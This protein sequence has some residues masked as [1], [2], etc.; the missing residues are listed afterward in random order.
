[1]T[2]W[3]LKRFRWE[4]N[5][6]PLHALACI[7]SEGRVPRTVSHCLPGRMG[8]PGR[9]STNVPQTAGWRRW[10]PETQGP[11]SGLASSSDLTASFPGQFLRNPLAQGHKRTCTRCSRKQCLHEWKTGTR[12]PRAGKGGSVMLDSPESASCE[13]LG[14]KQCR[15]CGCGQ[16]T[17]TASIDGAAAKPI[18]T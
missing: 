12:Y 11:G 8:T 2:P 10:T 14:G 7:S 15:A 18:S 6:G 4:S 1:M 5:Q 17:E 9:S 16:V 13:C 3:G